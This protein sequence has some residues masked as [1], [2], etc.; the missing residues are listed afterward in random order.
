MLTSIQINR[1]LFNQKRTN[2]S[3]N[4]S[5]KKN[6]LVDIRTK[7]NVSTF[8][9]EISDLYLKTVFINENITKSS[10]VSINKNIHQALICSR[11]IPLLCTIDWHGKSVT[12]R[13]SDGSI[14]YI[15]DAIDFDGN[16]H[17]I[18]QMI[19]YPLLRQSETT[20]L[21][22]K[23]IAVLTDGGYV[24]SWDISTG[25]LLFCTFTCGDIFTGINPIVE[26]DIIKISYGIDTVAY[27]DLRGSLIQTQF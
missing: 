1:K 4:S 3:F 19:V 7:P 23:Y 2:Y 9:A 13:N 26:E 6:I 18:I 17:S 27:I 22:H 10:I 25:E 14:V 8:V 11:P 5:N 21:S 12:V 15:L 16:K 24:F 20:I